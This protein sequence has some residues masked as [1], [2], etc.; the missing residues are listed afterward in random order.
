MES[1]VA[2]RKDL[3]LFVGVIPKKGKPGNWRSICPLWMGTA[4]TTDGRKITLICE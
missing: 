3:V 4:L 1:R 2:H